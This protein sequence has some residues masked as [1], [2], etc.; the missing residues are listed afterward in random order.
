MRYRIKLLTNAT[1]SGTEHNVGEPGQYMFRCDGTFGG[2]TVSLQ[3]RSPDGVNWLDITDASVTAEG[4][5]LVNLAGEVGVRAVVTG[6]APSGL[7]AT[8][9]KA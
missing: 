7:Y 2:A 4:S 8:L 9:D 1:A 6:G 5:F 3:Q